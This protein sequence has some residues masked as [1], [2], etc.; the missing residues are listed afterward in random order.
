MNKIFQL[1]L[2][3]VFLLAVSPCIWS[4]QNNASINAAQQDTPD[5]IGK[6]K[7]NCPLKH[8][9]GCAEVIFTGQPVHVAVGSLAP[10]NGVGAG[11][12][13]VG[14]WTT[15]NWRNSWNADSVA[16]ANGSWRAGF[17]LK[18]VDSRQSDIP[19]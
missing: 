14:H 11:L 15:E 16:T 9:I 12:A 2:L 3:A 4:Q 5:E 10:Q 18:F 1:V 6:L 7:K 17:Y 13:L 19:I 8:V